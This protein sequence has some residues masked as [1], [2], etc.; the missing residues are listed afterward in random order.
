MSTAAVVAVVLT[1][2]DA[3]IGAGLAAG[4]LVGR[5]IH[6]RDQQTPRD[7]LGPRR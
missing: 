4:V 7:D 1:V 3:W 2:L 6:R 5:A